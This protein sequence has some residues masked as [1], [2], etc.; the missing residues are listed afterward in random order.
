VCVSRRFHTLRMGTY[1]QGDENPAWLRFINNIPIGRRITRK[2]HEKTG[3]FGE[4]HYKNAD[5]KPL[6]GEGALSK[7]AGDWKLIME[8]ILEWQG[9]RPQ[10]ILMVRYENLKT[11]PETEIKKVLDFIDADASPEII[12]EMIAQNS[13]SKLKK[14]EQG[15][16]FFRKGVV[17]DWRNHFT[18]DDVQ[19]FKQLTG[20]LLVRLN[21]ETNTDWQ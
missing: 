3:W 1:Y 21:Y 9:Q 13:F 4:S 20:D 15:K 7:F 6:F 10:Q 5:S 16:S 17:G 11:T 2:L 18:P 12:E 8:Y 19:L 14:T